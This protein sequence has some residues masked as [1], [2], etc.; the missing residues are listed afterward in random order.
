[1]ARVASSITSLKAK[2]AEH[3]L[4]AK[5]LNAQIKELENARALAIGKLIVGAESKNWEGFD[6]TVF[7]TS[8]ASLS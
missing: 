4:K 8:I 3:A 7:K 5:E 6:L 1:M 2:A